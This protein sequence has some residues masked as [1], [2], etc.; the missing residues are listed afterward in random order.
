MGEGILLSQGADVDFMIHGVFSYQ[1]FGQ[2]FWITTTHICLLIVLLVI[3]GF[4]IAASRAMK[5]ASLVPGGFQNIVELMV[6]KL[7][8][9][10]EGVMGKN[11]AGFAN[12]IGTIFIFIFLSNIS[13]L[14]GLR[15]PRCLQ[16][17]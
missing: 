17:P 16:C 2:E 4:C 13:G 1:L 15:P 11:A 7:D 6:E 14:F 8:G 5:H 10:V 9:M 12:Y 3:V